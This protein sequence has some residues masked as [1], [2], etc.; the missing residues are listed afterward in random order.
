MDFHVILLLFSCIG[1]ILLAFS[2]A[3][4]IDG[5]INVNVSNTNT[6]VVNNANVNKTIVDGQQRNLIESLHNIT[7]KLERSEIKRSDA[8]N[9]LQQLIGGKSDEHQQKSVKSVAKSGKKVS[10]KIWRFFDA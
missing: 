4:E 9:A 1:S 2:C 7:E 10:E 5:T 3:D 8:L 6:A